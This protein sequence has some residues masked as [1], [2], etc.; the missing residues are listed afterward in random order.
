MPS[1]KFKKKARN[2]LVKVRVVDW[3][4]ERWRKAAP[5]G[6]ISAWLRCLADTE[7][8]KRESERSCS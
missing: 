3:E 2:D 4:K 8:R 5:R 6:N 1:I 7:L